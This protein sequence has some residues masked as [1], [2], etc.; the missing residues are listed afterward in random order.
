MIKFR[1]DIFYNIRLIFDSVT[2]SELKN[3][4]VVKNIWGILY[5]SEK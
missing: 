4:K 2:S 1:Q 3:R 5:I